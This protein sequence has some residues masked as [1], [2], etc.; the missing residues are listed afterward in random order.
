MAR[1]FKADPSQDLSNGL[2]VYLSQ[3]NETRYHVIGAEMQ[4][5]NV[6]LKG[7]DSKL[8]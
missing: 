6:E 1:V 3:A 7:G 2:S 4:I 5:V 8:S